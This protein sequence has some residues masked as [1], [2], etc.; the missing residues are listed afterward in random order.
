MASPEAGDSPRLWSRPW[1]ST[2]RFS[3]LRL[4]TPVAD[5]RRGDG[6][7][8]TSTFLGFLRRGPSGCRST[9]CQIKPRGSRSETGWKQNW[10]SS[11]D[12]T[13]ERCEN[14]IYHQDALRFVQPVIVSNIR[15]YDAYKESRFARCS[16]HTGQ[17]AAAIVSLSSTDRLDFSFLLIVDSEMRACPS[18]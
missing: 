2:N 13:V 9:S 8:S 16:V 10:K 3:G 12:N 1:R 14:M 4:T 5:T 18:G 11:H 7:G 17:D 6:S 15:L